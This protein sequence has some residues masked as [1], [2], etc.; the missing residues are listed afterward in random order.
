[1]PNGPSLPEKDTM[2]DRVKDAPRAR[3]LG[4]CSRL[5]YSRAMH[6]LHYIQFQPV[7]RF[8]HRSTSIIV[9]IWDIKRS[10]ISRTINKSIMKRCFCHYSVMVTVTWRVSVMVTLSVTFLFFY[11]TFTDDVTDTSCA[12]ITVTE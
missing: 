6:L 2:P 10:T 4:W 1:M 9:F 5:R 11:V 3:G 12:T 7:L 8:H